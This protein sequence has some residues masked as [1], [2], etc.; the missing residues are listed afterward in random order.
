M[1]GTLEVSFRMALSSSLWEKNHCVK[2]N[3]SKNTKVNGIEGYP[4]APSQPMLTAS[5][6]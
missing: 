2:I 3:P 1:L 6:L 5:K 4:A